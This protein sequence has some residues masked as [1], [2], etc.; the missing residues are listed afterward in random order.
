M[1]LLVM[2]PKKI[3]IDVVTR[4]DQMKRKCISFQLMTSANKFNHH[5]PQTNECGSNKVQFSTKQR[6]PTSDLSGVNTIKLYG[7]VLNYLVHLGS[8]LLVD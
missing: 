8:L 3:V 1:A 7:S 6:T 5:R 4:G 2:Q